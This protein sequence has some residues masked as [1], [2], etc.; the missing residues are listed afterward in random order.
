MVLAW[1]ICT[2]QLFDNLTK[3]TLDDNSGMVLKKHFQQEIYK[4]GCIRGKHRRI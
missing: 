2:L 3:N 1:M 4:S